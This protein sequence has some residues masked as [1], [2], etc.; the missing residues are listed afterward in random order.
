M[1]DSQYPDSMSLDKAA[2]VLPGGRVEAPP[3]WPL[4]RGD[5]I[6]AARKILH[7]A[8]AGEDSA[9]ELT[10]EDETLLIAQM[11]TA[12]VSL[13]PYDDNAYLRTAMSQA[14]MGF[15]A[16]ADGLK[17]GSGKSYADIVNHIEALSIYCQE[18]G[19]ADSAAAYSLRVHGI[20]AKRIE[21]LEADLKQLN[22][23][24]DTFHINIK[25]LRADTEFRL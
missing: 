2:L 14:A 13:Q 20:Q 10:T 17:R 21:K 9:G 5:M 23:H 12:M 4:I 3:V 16:I 22:A 11:Y 6:E 18:F 8:L 15:R 19:E 24:F 1:P 7:G 25:G